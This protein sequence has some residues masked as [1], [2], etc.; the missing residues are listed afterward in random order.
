MRRE[1][2]HPPSKWRPDPTTVP[3]AEQISIL[4]IEENILPWKK[5]KKK[6]LAYLIRLEGLAYIFIHQMN[7]NHLPNKNYPVMISELSF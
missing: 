5:K 6:L 4:Q 2:I 3:G 1:L 7:Q